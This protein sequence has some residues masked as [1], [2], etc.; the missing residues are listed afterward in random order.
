MQLFLQ[1]ELL[2]LTITK[3]T[4][5]KTRTFFLA[6]IFLAQLVC[7]HFSLTWAFSQA[8]LTNFWRALWTKVYKH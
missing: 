1:N 3:T 6:S 5:K 8:F 4:T 7:S 2:A